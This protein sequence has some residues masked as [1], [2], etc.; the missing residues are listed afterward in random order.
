[1]HSRAKMKR[2]GGLRC[3]SSSS[4]WLRLAIEYVTFYRDSEV[5][6]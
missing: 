5:N 2:M 1:M 6:F 4:D 3:D